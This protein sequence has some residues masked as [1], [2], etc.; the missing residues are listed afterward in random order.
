MNYF[1]IACNLKSANHFD[2]MNSPRANFIWTISKVHGL[3][4]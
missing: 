1:N 3:T 4:V 2:H